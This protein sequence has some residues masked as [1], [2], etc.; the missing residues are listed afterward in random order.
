[1][2]EERF[3]YFD[4]IQKTSNNWIRYL[5]K[6]YIELNGP[7]IH[8]F[9]MDKKKMEIDELYMTSDDK[10][11]LEPFKI[12][13]IHFDNE[14][15]GFLGLDVF[16]EIEDNLEVMV[17]FDNMIQIIRD[18]KNKKRVSIF[19]EP[20]NQNT[21]Y[22]AE[23]KDNKLFIYKDRELYEEIDL[24]NYQTTDKLINYLKT[25]GDFKITSEGKNSSSSKLVDFN[26][27]RFKSSKLEIYVED[28]TYR[29]IT[30]VI[31]NGDVLLTHDNRFYEVIEAKPAGNYGWDYH[32]YRL[33][34]KKSVVNDY[35]LPGRWKER[36]L[37]NE[38][39]L[40]TVDREGKYEGGYIG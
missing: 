8:L 10:L 18:L 2:T 28:P 35:D 26:K 19:I 38:L 4:E 22:D 24:S 36:A 3:N 1:M 33:T 31:E 21:I 6:E 5:N 27:T 11:F 14:F 20:K 9:K 29:E 16:G 40:G 13:G 25:F 32:L 17:N 7:E 34:C 12:R 37:K 39:N 30:D 23:K 15:R